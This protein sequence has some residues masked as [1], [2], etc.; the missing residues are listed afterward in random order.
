[1][2]KSRR[3]DERR[4]ERRDHHLELKEN[5]EQYEKYDESNE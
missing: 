1:M 4:D 5:C 2:E 3:R